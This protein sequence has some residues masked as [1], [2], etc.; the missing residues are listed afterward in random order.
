MPG[1]LEF[2]SVG[3]VE[4]RAGQLG[5]EFSGLL[6]RRRGRLEAAETLRT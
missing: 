2:G 6:V 1:D 4:K 3:C 5:W